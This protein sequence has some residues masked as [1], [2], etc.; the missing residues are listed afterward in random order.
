MTLKDAVEAAL[1]LP[2]EMFNHFLACVPLLVEYNG[3]PLAKGNVVREALRLINQA[4][5]VAPTSL[6]YLEQGSARFPLQAPPL[7]GGVI[8][9]LFHS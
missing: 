7:V 8:D 3:L 9:H 5:K 6:T 4:C 1:L 2:S